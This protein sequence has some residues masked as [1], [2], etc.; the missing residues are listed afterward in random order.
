MNQPTIYTKTLR[1]V[2]ST[3]SSTSILY[4]GG[5]QQIG[6]IIDM[7]VLAPYDGASSP[8]NL[9]GEAADRATIESCNLTLKQ[10]ATELFDQVPLSHLLNY[11]R[12]NGEGFPINHKIDLSESRIY[13]AK[14]IVG[15]KI[16]LITI[17]YVKP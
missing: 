5:E 1:C 4:D 2:L 3:D 6:R 12:A 9:G 10:G 7:R 15:K 13:C 16:I 8:N 14:P 17:S 11:E